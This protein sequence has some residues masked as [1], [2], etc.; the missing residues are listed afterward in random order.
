MISH[1]N[2]DMALTTLAFAVEGLT[3]A[4]CAI[5]LERALK[6]DASVVGVEISVVAGSLTVTTR[7]EETAQQQLSD[8]LCATASPLGFAMVRAAAAGAATIVFDVSGGA[9][10]LQDALVI[11]RSTTG[12]ASA[13]VHRGS[14]GER[15]AISVSYY[16]T[17]VGARS[18]MNDGGAGSLTLCRHGAT[19]K[20]DPHRVRFVSALGLAFVSII[21]QYAIPRDTG[22]YDADLF[23]V[24]TPRVLVM[25]LLA[26]GAVFVFGLPL[27]RSALASAWISHVMTMDTLVS[28]SSGITYIYATVLVLSSW[29]G[30]STAGF[31][32]PPF[33]TVAILLG[34]VAFGREIEASSKRQTLQALEQLARLQHVDAV[35]VGKATAACCSSSGGV[36]DACA[37]T[38]KSK[39]VAFGC[40]NT[41]ASSAA[42]DPC[43]KGSDGAAPCKSSTAQTALLSPFDDIA[44]PS[45]SDA[46]APTV[47]V[48]AATDAAPVSAS[49][50]SCCKS[51]SCKSSAAKITLMSPSD[52]IATSLASDAAAPTVFSAAT[53]AAPV[54]A[55]AKPCCKSGSCKSLTAKAA[56]LSPYDDL[57]APSSSA[58]AVSTPT[59][60]DAAADATSDAASDA[61]SVPAA[62]ASAKPCCAS[63]PCQ[64]STTDRLISGG[65]SPAAE[66]LTLAVNLPVASYLDAASGAFISIPVAP[67][68]TSNRSSTAGTNIAP[69]LVEI[70]DLLVVGPGQRFPADGI[71][72]V[73]CTSVDE[74]M[75]T[76]ESR[77]VLKVVGDAVVGATL[78]SEG[79]VHVKVTA[80][81]SMGV[82]AQIAALITSAQGQRPRLQ[83]T[84]DIISSWFTPLILCEWL[85]PFMRCI[86][87]KWMLLLCMIFCTYK[88]IVCCML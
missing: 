72:V 26:T 9:V 2:D 45:A 41:L 8:R 84:A 15:G 59:V 10:A 24:L 21:M 5:Q 16:P 38:T 62:S 3:C 55:P 61:A 64:P 81:P 39:S 67:L 42:D 52:D 60:V 25:W 66:F 23:G 18:L 46:T 80:L 85:E 37:S 40:D 74:S 11:L 79:V 73:G 57:A 65:T 7:E 68:K 30:S 71:V 36:S 51:G 22:S 87:C 50:K 54:S 56:L 69:E 14:H 53:D 58:A 49:V 86:I 47:V 13:A 44:A 4:D 1:T 35:L 19:R 70:G 43:R 33:E 34:L 88:Y 31:G 77:P 29:A 78:N 75:I 63:G 32:E 27:F 6:A 17:I 83:L 20:G 12:V 28:L 48:A 76:G 82:I